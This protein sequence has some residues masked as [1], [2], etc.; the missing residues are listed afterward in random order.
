MS[1]GGRA[2]AAVAELGK[3][4]ERALQGKALRVDGA[5]CALRMRRGYA[6]VLVR[7]DTRFVDAQQTRV[8]KTQGAGF[9]G[10]R[11]ASPRVE[12]RL[13]PWRP[14]QTSPAG[15]ACAVKLG[16]PQTPR[17]RRKVHAAGCR[18]MK[19]AKYRQDRGRVRS[20]VFG[21][22]R[23]GLTYCIAWRQVSGWLRGR[24]REQMDAWWHTVGT[25]IALG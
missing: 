12:F 6:T 25:R 18:R 24:W 8:A 4:G 13:M 10:W 3:E 19:L 7:Q 1:G 21:K 16:G 11:A 23:L 22:R 9:L 2:A 17:H 14:C 15:I 5:R 20:A